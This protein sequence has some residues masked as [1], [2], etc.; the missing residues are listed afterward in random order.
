M[1]SVRGAGAGPELCHGCLQGHSALAS[2]IIISGLRE[3]RRP[4]RERAVEAARAR[5]PGGAGGV[6]TEMDQ[7]AGDPRGEFAKSNAVRLDETRRV[8]VV[9]EAVVAG[10]SL[11]HRRSFGAGLVAVNEAGL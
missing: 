4:A 6:L 8:P 10:L 2:T 11:M 3:S 1:G 9:S 5:R 7:R